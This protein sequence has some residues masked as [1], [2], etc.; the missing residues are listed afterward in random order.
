LPDTEPNL[1]CGPI[2]GGP[3]LRQAVPQAVHEDLERTYTAFLLCIRNTGKCLWALDA[4]YSTKQN[5]HQPLGRLGLKGNLPIQLSVGGHAL[6][7]SSLGLSRSD[8]G[9]IAILL[10]PITH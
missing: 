1:S 3:P 9:P 10:V 4:L 7:A 8:K 6:V 2:E 5:P